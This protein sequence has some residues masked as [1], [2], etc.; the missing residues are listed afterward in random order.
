MTDELDHSGR[1]NLRRASVLVLDGN[2]QALDLMRQIL[3]GFGVRSI[4][5]AETAK[6]ARALFNTHVLDLVIVDPLFNDGSGYEFMRWARREEDAANRCVGVIAAMGHQ[7]LTNVRM[8]RDA[9]ANLVVAKPLSP[10]VLLRRI[11][12]VAREKRSFIVA[13][14]YVGPDRR[15]KNEGPPPGINGRRCDDLSA[16]VPVAV[17]PNMSQNEVDELFKPRRISL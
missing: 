12:W 4:H 2:P 11:T 6:D 10:D 13:P 14:G 17:M 1:I 7:T 8:A 9:G 3:A 5:V 15:F 16:E